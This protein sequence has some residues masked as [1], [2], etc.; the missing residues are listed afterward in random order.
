MTAKFRLSAFGDEISADLAEQLQTLIGLNVHGLDLRGA[1]GKN[2]AKMDDEDV[3]RVKRICGE[4]GVKIAC[5][6]SPVGKSPLGEPANFELGNLTRLMAIGKT[7]GT[8]LIR[9]FF[10]LPA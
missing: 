7:L 4:T 9:I 5:L 8:P 1:W 6:G 2:V 10:V 3:A